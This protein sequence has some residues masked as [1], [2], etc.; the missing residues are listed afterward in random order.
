MLLKSKLHEADP[1]SKPTGKAVQGCANTSGVCVFAY[2]HTF[3]KHGR[4][5]TFPEQCRK[6]LFRA[7]YGGILGSG[8]RSTASQ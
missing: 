7:G 2:P 4:L 3:L 6:C 8:G 5:V 1:H